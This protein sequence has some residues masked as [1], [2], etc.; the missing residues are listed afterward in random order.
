[1]AHEIPEKWSTQAMCDYVVERGSI[2]EALSSLPEAELK[3]LPLRERVEEEKRAESW[4]KILPSW[5]SMEERLTVELRTTAAAEREARVKRGRVRAADVRFD[6]AVGRLGGEVQLA[7][8]NNPKAAPYTTLFATV[9]ISQ[10]RG[11]GPK[12][13][14][15][16]GRTVAAK[17]IALDGAFEGAAHRVDVFS[18]MLEVVGDERDDLTIVQAE[19][20]VRKIKLHAALEELVAQTDRAITGFLP[21]VEAKAVARELL[22]PKAGVAKKTT[23]QDAPAAEA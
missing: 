7:S 8:G 19:A 6:G 3:R 18:R 15:G 20:Q 11:F 10:A 17:A 12:K 13:A 5:V 4:R 23:K 2:I 1:M 22:S 21:R 14:G 16:W 9:T